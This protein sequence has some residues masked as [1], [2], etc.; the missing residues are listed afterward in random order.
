M[1]KDNQ[2]LWI[3]EILTKAELVKAAEVKEA[4]SLAGQN[5]LPLGQVLIIA[6][7][8]S[9]EELAAAIQAQSLIKDDVLEMKVATQA[10]KL[11]RGCDLS[12]EEAL[13]QLGWAP[14]QKKT[15]PSNRL[16][17]LLV[18]AELMSQEDL[19]HALK[20]CSTTGLPLGRVVTAMGL[21]SHGLLGAV[22]TAQVMLRDGTVTREQ[23]ILGLRAAKQRSISLEQS[24][25]D[26]GLLQPKK[27][28]AVQIGQLLRLS[29]LV[30]EA[31]VI[32]ALEI[33]LTS[34]K[35]VGQVL[36]DRGAINKSLLYAALKVQSLIAAGQ[37]HAL[38]GI[39]VMRKMH[40]Q[41]ISI[42]E[43]ISTLSLTLPP[44]GEDTVPLVQLLEKSSILDQNDVRRAVEIAYNNT[45]I[46]GKILLIAG[47]IDDDLLE[48][49]TRCQALLR[50]GVLGEEQAIIALQYCR[51]SKLSIYDALEQVGWRV[52]VSPPAPESKEI[53]NTTEERRAI[54]ERS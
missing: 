10:L 48:A 16:G 4:V 19:D 3:G 20:A 5:G 7:R 44:I 18:G 22:L 9:E 8:L 36:V 14:K 33:S 45:E 32:D 17:E 52:P 28:P 1:S 38:Q 50:Q 23:A 26:Q 15:T 46:M 2:S 49:A 53:S 43:A 6:G 35:P 13:I 39:Q 54:E 47:V 29:G 40:T 21:M 11:V 37:I 25:K 31:D 34:E 42:E 24:L 30:T 27:G 51:K 12:L 41:G